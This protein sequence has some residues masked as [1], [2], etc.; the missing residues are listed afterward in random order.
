MNK[1]LTKGCDPAKVQEFKEFLKYNELF[2][3]LREMLREDIEACR[4]DRRSLKSLIQ[5][6][7]SE[8]QADRNA[9]E[10][11]FIK[12]LEAIKPS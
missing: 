10:R 8:Y 7:Y 11:A 12:V 2:E 9:T 5:Q 6:N 4:T 3:S 1:R